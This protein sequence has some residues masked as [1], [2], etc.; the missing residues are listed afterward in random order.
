MKIIK[1]YN[2]EIDNLLK[3][4]VLPTDDEIKH[5][6]HRM[7][8]S[9]ANKRRWTGAKGRQT[10]QQMN[11][12]INSAKGKKDR[13][14]KGKKNQALKSYPFRIIFPDGTVRNFK[15]HYEAIKEFGS[16]NW[17][18]GILPTKGA[19]RIERKAFKNCVIHRTDIMV[20]QKYVDKLVK[21]AYLK[22]NPPKKKRD[23]K[24]WAEKMEAW[25]K[26]RKG[27][28]F[29]NSSPTK[30]TQNLK[31]ARQIQTPKGVFDSAT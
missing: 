5:D 23:H 25:R 20:D 18:P 10:R 28:A 16:E 21:E 3:D 12:Y 19:K 24:A 1:D 15:G 13:A 4:V 17:N 31:N 7:K 26:S 30:G 6:T 22:V 8:N 29:L 2:W 11:T 9:L 14:D 27:K